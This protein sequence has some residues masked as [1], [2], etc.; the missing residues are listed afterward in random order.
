MVAGEMSGYL[1]SQLINLYIYI[2]L[3]NNTR[4]PAIIVWINYLFSLIIFYMFYTLMNLSVI[5]TDTYWA[6]YFVSLII[7]GIE[8][9]F[10]T[11]IDVKIKRGLEK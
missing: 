4:S 9:F 7:Q 3:L 2:F 5:V 11:V 6:G 1:I 10:A 8:C